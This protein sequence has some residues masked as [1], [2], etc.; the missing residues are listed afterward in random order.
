M[1]IKAKALSVNKCWQG[2]RFKTQ[3]Y[4]AYEEEILYKLKPLELPEAPYTLFVEVGLSSKLADIDNVAKPFID[5]LQK[6]Y[7]FNDKNIYQ[8]VMTKSDVKKGEE[9]LDFSFEHYER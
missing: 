5:I 9:Y 7:G 4:K 6:K 2:R 3:D 8:L 1:Q